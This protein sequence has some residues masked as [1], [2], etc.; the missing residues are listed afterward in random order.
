M[1]KIKAVKFEITR[2][3]GPT[4]LCGKKTPVSSWKEADA[5]FSEVARTAP[6][7]GG[8]DKCD[9]RITFEDGETYEGRMDVKGNPDENETL[10]QHVGQLAR[11][12]AGRRK[13][14]HLNQQQYDDF[15]AQNESYNPGLANSYAEFL[16][17]YEIPAY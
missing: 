8:Y 10:A 17:K 16:D 2:A 15:L 12:Y 11:F 1:G 7:T 6:T 14:D 13:P 3:E 4:H 9:F 5:I